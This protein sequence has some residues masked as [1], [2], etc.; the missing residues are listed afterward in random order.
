MY[1]N[2]VRISITVANRR[3]KCPQCLRENDGIPVEENYVKC[4]YCQNIE[5]RDLHGRESVKILD[6]EAD[7]LQTRILQASQEVNTIK[8]VSQWP[9][10]KA[11]L[12]SHILRME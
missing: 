3:F 9:A 4:G 5:D 11:I 7:D 6:R 8:K 10:V 12:T 1:R 2:C